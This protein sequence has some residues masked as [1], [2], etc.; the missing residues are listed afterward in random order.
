MYGL[1]VGV[2][3]LDKETLPLFYGSLYLYQIKPKRIGLVTA[4]SKLKFKFSLSASKS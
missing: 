4:Q 2:K 3:G 1:A